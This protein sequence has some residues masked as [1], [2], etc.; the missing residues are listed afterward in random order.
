MRLRTAQLA[1]VDAPT[2]PR[3]VPRGHGMAAEQPPGQLR[4]SKFNMHSVTITDGHRK[5]CTHPNTL[6]RI[7]TYQH[8]HTNTHTHTHAH[9]HTHKHTHGNQP[10][11]RVLVSRGTLHTIAGEISI[12]RTRRTCR[13]T[14][15]AIHSGTRLCTDLG[16]PMRQRE[17]QGHQMRPRRQGH[18]LTLID[19]KAQPKRRLC[20]PLKCEGQQ[21]GDN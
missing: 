8:T 16:P 5:T 12:R 15:G 11:Y 19:T 2:L 7:L 17:Q 6:I 18:G 1:G 20:F 3:A 21:M 4:K 13:A 14:Q 9:A 10:Q